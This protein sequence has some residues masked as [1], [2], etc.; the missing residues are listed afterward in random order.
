MVLVLVGHLA[1]SMATVFKP[2]RALGWRFDHLAN[3]AMITA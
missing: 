2:D 1:R 3:L